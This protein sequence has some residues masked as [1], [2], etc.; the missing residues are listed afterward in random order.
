MIRRAIVAA[1][2]PVL[3]L[4]AAATPVA[5]AK[6]VEEARFTS[7]VPQF[8][9]MALRAAPLPEADRIAAF[10]REVVPL[11]PDFYRPHGSK[12]EKYW[13][14]VAKEIA[15]YP[16]RRDGIRNAARLVEGARADAG[17]RFRRSFPDYRA[18]TPVYLLHSLGEMD[19]GTR[20]VGGR[21]V[22]IFGADVIARFHD[23]SS[24]GPLFDHEL[25]HTYH[26][27]FFPECARVWCQLWTEGMAV[28]VAERMNAGASDRAL[29]LDFP[30]PIRP[31]VDRD[32]PAVVAQ[33]RAAL[34]H[35]EGPDVDRMFAMG[36]PGPGLP[37]R[38]G[39]LV[40]LKIA[41]RLGRTRS[42][43]QLAHLRPAQVRP[44]IEHTLDEMAA[45]R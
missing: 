35:E 10:R 37:E 29:L 39:Y 4:A 15:D 36:R 7:L 3:A 16:A 40:G 17:V 26:A 27:A 5:S 9:R 20:T 14:V 8:D 1:L 28:Y 24:I 44:L 32:F 43:A 41:E 42:L 30:A 11:L 31:A 33:V 22:L 18:T 21:T 23:A 6:R 25:F 34:D 38:Y 45:P 19:G 2:A 12:P 13:A